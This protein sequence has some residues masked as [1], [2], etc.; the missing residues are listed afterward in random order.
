MTDYN[1]DRL[2]VYEIFMCF[3]KFIHIKNMSYFIAGS[4]STHSKIIR[5]TGLL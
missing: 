2:E 5:K 3:L 4:F 1:S